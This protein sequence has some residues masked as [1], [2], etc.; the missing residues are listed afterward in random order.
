MDLFLFFA[1]LTKRGEPLINKAEGRYSTWDIKFAHRFQ[2]FA[3]LQ[4]PGPLSYSDYLQAT[5]RTAA[6]VANGALKG[7]GTLTGAQ[8][9]VTVLNNLT[10]GA[11]LCFQHARKLFDEAK[12]DTKNTDHKYVNATITTLTKVKSKISPFFRTFL[13]D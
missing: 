10:Q 13:F 7:P 11:Q 9:D 4:N 2:A 5:D 8:R 3:E 1:G 12:S 6:S